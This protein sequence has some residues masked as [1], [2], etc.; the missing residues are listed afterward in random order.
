MSVAG[1]GES[2]VVLGGAYALAGRRHRWQT[3]LRLARRHPVGAAALIVLL[4]LMLGAVFAGQVT[5]YSPTSLEGNRLEGPTAQHLLGTDR[6]GRDIFTRIL[7]GARISLLISALAVGLGTLTGSAIGIASGFL[8]GWFD[9][10]VQ[11]LMDVL[12]S[13]PAL[14][15]ALVIVASFGPGVANAMIAIAIVLVPTS[16]RVIRSVALQLKTRTFVEAARASG[17]SGLRILARHVVPNAM[18]EVLILASVA[19]AAAVIIEAAL[20]FLGLGAQPPT[21]SW[22]Q[23]LA[24]GRS[25]YLRAPHMVWVPSLAISVTVLAVTLLGDTIRDI[26]DPKTRGGQGV[27][28]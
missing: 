5:P 16:A 19:L 20:S 27:H 13:I 11:R 2:A 18:D 9:L 26:V 6:I 21:P 7:Y 17:A 3:A 22:G 4:A 1:T 28:F 12:M 23:M 10:I 15:L 24:E 8:G 25:N 14:L